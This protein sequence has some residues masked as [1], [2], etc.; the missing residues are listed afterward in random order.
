MGVGFEVVGRL[1]VDL[2]LDHVAEPPDYRFISIFLSL[3]P[4]P[5]SVHS[6]PSIFENSL[7]FLEFDFF[8]HLKKF[9]YIFGS[10]SF[11]LRPC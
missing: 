2:K 7:Q 5:P 3:A 6:Q 10:K 9:D 11:N 8:C 1:E 4:S